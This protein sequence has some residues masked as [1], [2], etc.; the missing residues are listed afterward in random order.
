MLSKDKLFLYIAILVVLA[1]C[2]NWLCAPMGQVYFLDLTALPTETQYFGVAVASTAIQQEELFL[3][4]AFA[5][6]LALLCLG[7]SKPSS[8]K[9]VFHTL[10]LQQALAPGLA[11]CLLCP[12]KAIPASI[13]DTWLCTQCMEMLHL[14]CP[15]QTALLPIHRM[16]Y[17]KPMFLSGKSTSNWLVSCSCQSLSRTSFLALRAERLEK[18]QET[19]KKS[20]I[21]LLL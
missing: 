1:I 5:F 14:Y 7:F 18:W 4:L 19:G 21:H 13:A 3:C 12:V 9:P 15:K 8:Q 6:H 10:C 17:W 20:I 16:V 2:V 11:S